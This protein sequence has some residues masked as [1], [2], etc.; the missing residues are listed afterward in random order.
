MSP[1]KGAHVD[2]LCGENMSAIGVQEASRGR[3]RCSAGTRPERLA[4]TNR[5]NPNR[6]V[7]L[8]FLG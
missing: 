7:R 3:V 1:T 5:E 2:R 8:S 6:Q 4:D